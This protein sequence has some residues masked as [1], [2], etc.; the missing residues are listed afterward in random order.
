[1]SI[2]IKLQNLNLAGDTPVTLTY[3]AGTSVFVHNETAVD[4]AISETDVISQFSELVATPGI[5]ATDT[6][7]NNIMNNMRDS[8]FLEGYERDFTFAEYLT[9]ALSENFYEQEFIGSSVEQ[10]DYKRGFCTLETTVRVPLQDFI[11]SSP[12]ASGWTVTVPT[13]NGTLTIS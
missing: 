5:N 2:T 4:T 7:G 13:E 9:D 1:M 6:Y 3:S 8:G 10:Y 11:T 12:Y